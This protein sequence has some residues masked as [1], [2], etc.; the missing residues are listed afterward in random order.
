MVATARH[1]LDKD[2]DDPGYRL[3][4]VTTQS[5]FASKLAGQGILSP[6]DI[7]M[8]EAESVPARLYAAHRDLI[9]EGERPGPVFLIQTGWACR[10]KV[11]P[12][13]SRQIM[14]FLMPGDFCDLHVGVLEEMDHSIGAVTDCQVVV[15]P[16]DRMDA[17][18]IAS[19]ALTRAFWRTQL[20]DAG[21]AARLDRQ[22]GAT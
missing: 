8:I 19:P 6:A 17:L 11:L 10:Y 21:R 12:D 4:A 14:A 18:I 22:H 20:V 16:R 13:G 1:N 3:S 7:V 5:A 9:R 15:I 2:R